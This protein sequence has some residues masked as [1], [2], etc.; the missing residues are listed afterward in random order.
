MKIE[1]NLIIFGNT[2]KVS[3]F[4]SVKVISFKVV[5]FFRIPDTAT[6]L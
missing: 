6:M 3:K 4:F 2:L 5:F 1:K